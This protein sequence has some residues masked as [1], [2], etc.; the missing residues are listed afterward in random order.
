M[1]AAYG[2]ESGSAPVPR[3]VAQV[4]ADGWDE[5][6]HKIVEM[7]SEF[8]EDKYNFKPAPEVRTFAEQL[9]H[10]ATGTVYLAKVAHGEKTKYVELQREKYPTKA[11]IVGVLKRSFDEVSSLLKAQGDEQAKARPGLW[12]GLLEHAGEHYGQLVVYYRLNGIVPPE[13]RPKPKS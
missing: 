11:D 6:G 9:L 12:I 13:S 5:V 8:P 3:T 2:Q 1:A 7:A 4:L 10:A